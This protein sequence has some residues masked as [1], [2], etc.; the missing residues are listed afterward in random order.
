MRGQLFQRTASGDN[1]FVP[2]GPNLIERGRHLI[3][4]GGLL[5]ALALLMTTEL[6]WYGKPISGPPTRMPPLPPP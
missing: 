2:A 4:W 1:F 3:E 5:G 6:A